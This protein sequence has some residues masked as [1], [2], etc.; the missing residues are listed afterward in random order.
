M[1]STCEHVS[2][3]PLEFWP[4]V[5]HFSLLFR[6]FCIFPYS[7]FCSRVCLSS[8]FPFSV[9]RFLVSPLRFFFF[10]DSSMVD[11]SAIKADCP[12]IAFFFTHLGSLLESVEGECLE[13]V[14]TFVRKDC[15]YPFVLSSLFPLVSHS[16]E[17]ARLLR[18]SE[19][20][21]SDLE[22]GLSSSDERV[23]SK[24]TSVSTPYKA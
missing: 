13:R 10:S 15:P 14:N 7:V 5:L 18:M 16:A 23:V 12:L 3:F 24:A 19:V 6:F 17:V 9:L 1:Y 4:L 20:R 8:E 22:M 11:Y 21:S 2:A